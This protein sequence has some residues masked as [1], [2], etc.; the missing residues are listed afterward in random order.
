[1]EMEIVDFKMHRP[2]PVDGWPE[3]MDQLTRD[4]MALEIALAEMDAA[5][6]DA[7]VINASIPFCELAFTRHPRQFAAM[8]TVG[9]GLP[10]SESIPVGGEDTEK[11][12]DFIKN[13]RALHSGPTRASGDLATKRWVGIR[14][15]LTWPP[16]TDKAVEPLREGVYEPI[17]E[18]AERYQVPTRVFLMGEI[19]EAVSIAKAHP[20]LVLIIDHLG[21]KAPPMM[22]LDNPPFRQLDLLLQL[23]HFPNVVV[24][25]SGAPALSHEKYPFSDLWP[26][27]LKIVSAFGP[28]RLFWGADHTRV[29]GFHTYSEAVNYIRYSNELSDHDKE[30]IF[31]LNLRRILRWPRWQ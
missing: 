21:M 7:A 24:D 25:I 14:L 6:V 19:Q 2:Q 28:E 5:G 30:L 15:V 22:R 16:P 17:F 31:G 18:A 12:I 3:L 1:M 23:S 9:I 10:P 11:A 4:A 29:K 26:S 13:M 8:P 20:D 27:L